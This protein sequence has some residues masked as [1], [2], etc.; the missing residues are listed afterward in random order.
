MKTDTDILLQCYQSG[1]MGVFKK[2]CEEFIYAYKAD[3]AMEVP[4]EFNLSKS[5]YARIEKHI[6]SANLIEETFKNGTA[7]LT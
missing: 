2:L 1:N 5:M 7:L 6:H 3:E 4:R